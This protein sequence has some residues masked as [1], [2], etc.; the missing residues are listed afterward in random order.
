MTIGA[1]AVNQIQIFVNDVLMGQSTKLFC[2]IL[3]YKL[4]SQ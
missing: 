1:K 4:E 3:K 2:L